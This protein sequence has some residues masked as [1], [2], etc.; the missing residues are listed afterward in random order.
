MFKIVV[1]KIEGSG[2]PVKKPK[3]RKQ[4]PRPIVKAAQEMM[5]AE[6][7]RKGRFNF[8]DES[9]KKRVEEV[10]SDPFN[11]SILTFQ[12]PW[13]VT[14]NINLNGIDILGQNGSDEFHQSLVSE[15]MLWN[16]EHF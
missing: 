3:P 5:M 9:K 2:T 16:K 14:G 1:N 8:K 15:H 13:D 10:K 11:I 4:S 6:H 12:K 7:L